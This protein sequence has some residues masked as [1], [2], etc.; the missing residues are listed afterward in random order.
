MIIVVVT[1][2]AKPM[3]SAQADALLRATAPAYRHI[4]GLHRKYFVGNDHIAGGVYQW[5]SRAD[6]DAYFDHAW[7]D[8]M[9]SVYQVE[10][11][12]EFF[13]LPC[14]VDN[15]AETTWFGSEPSG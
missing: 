4:P 9:Q 1:F 8:K 6:A 7:K 12:L 14:L 13:N 10:P 2:P 5:E 3:S 15:I 11:K